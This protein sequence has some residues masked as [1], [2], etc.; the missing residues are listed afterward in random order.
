MVSNLSVAQEGPSKSNKG[1]TVRADDSGNASSDSRS[2]STQQDR[3]KTAF[4]TKYGLYEHVRMG[5]GP[6]HFQ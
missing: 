6:C 2:V 5:Y 4:V 3:R 1:I